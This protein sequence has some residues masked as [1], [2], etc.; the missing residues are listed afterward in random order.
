LERGSQ[1][2]QTFK[3][4]ILPRLTLQQR[5][6]GILVAIFCNSLYCVSAQRLMNLDRWNLAKWPIKTTNTHCANTV[7][8]IPM[9]CIPKGHRAQILQTCNFYAPR[10]WTRSSKFVNVTY[11]GQ[12]M[13]STGQNHL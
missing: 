12:M 1:N 8:L 7:L 11:I 2:W 13:I 9:H 3:L 4:E 5:Y 6:N 10:N